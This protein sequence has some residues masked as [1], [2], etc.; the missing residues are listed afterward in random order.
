MRRF[1]L[2]SQLNTHA[3]HGAKLGWGGVEEKVR[4]RRYAW[5]P[6]FTH[7]PQPVL[8]GGNSQVPGSVQ[9]VEIQ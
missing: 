6:L 7:F 4:C 1:I 3:G 8:I 5:I 2:W 9:S